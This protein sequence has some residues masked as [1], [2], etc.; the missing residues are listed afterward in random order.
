MIKKNQGFSRKFLQLAVSGIQ[1]VDKGVLIATLFLGIYI[2]ISYGPLIKEWNVESIIFAISNRETT[3]AA[4]IAFIAALIAHSSAVVENRRKRDIEIQAARLKLAMLLPAL[5]DFCK[6]GA[7]YIFSCELIIKSIKNKED[8]ARGRALIQQNRPVKPSITPDATSLL[9]AAVSCPLIKVSS[10]I[11]SMAADL[12]TMERR[13]A[14]Y[15]DALSSGGVGV[16]YGDKHFDYELLNMCICKRNIDV[17]YDFVDGAPFL[18]NFDLGI[19]NS[20]CSVLEG[21]LISKQDVIIKLAD[22]LGKNEM[23]YI[24]K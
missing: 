21:R 9:E 1:S 20:S 13:M 23:R 17:L 11:A 2:F 19:Y 15:E 5:T 16:Y 10:H 7:H 12:K 14:G 22:K 3:N 24:R 4:I 6:E 8:G 18:S